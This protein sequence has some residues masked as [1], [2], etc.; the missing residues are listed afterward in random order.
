[1]NGNIQAPRARHL[2]HG[3]HAEDL[4]H[5]YL[6][7]H[8]L[9]TITRNYRCKRGE[10]DLVM[11]DADSLVFVEVRYRANQRFGTAAE[12]IFP[13]KM[14][15]LRRT[16]EHFLQRHSR[17]TKLYSRFDVIGITGTLNTPQIAWIKDAF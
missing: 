10:I 8:G 2:Q 16:A 3:R 14:H 6:L 12:T 13:G 4:A 9:N 7:K 17:Y 15:R 11:R 1:M 5:R